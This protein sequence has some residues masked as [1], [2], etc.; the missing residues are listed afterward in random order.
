MVQSIILLLDHKLYSVT[1]KEENDG[2]LLYLDTVI[3]KSITN[4]K[5]KV[6]KKKTNKDNL[7]HYYSGHDKKTKSGVVLDFFLCAYRICCD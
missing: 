5:F 1:V 4:I 7:M 2:Q 3:V 6:Y